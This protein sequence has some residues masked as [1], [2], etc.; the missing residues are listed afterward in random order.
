MLQRYHSQGRLLSGNT[1]A[2]SSCEGPSWCHSWEVY[3]EQI[4]NRVDLA[5][6]QRRTQLPGVIIP[7]PIYLVRRDCRLPIIGPRSP[8]LAPVSQF[9]SGEG[10]IL[11]SSEN[12][13]TEGCTSERRPSR[14]LPESREI[15][16]NRTKI[17][18]KVSGEKNRITHR[19]L[20]HS[21]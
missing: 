14:L 16:E 9:R 5:L 15:R 13:T 17:K 2:C 11:L 12:Q 6:R 19:W 10:M 20:R 4:Q 8:F 7:S 18:G 3:S 21:I 1:S